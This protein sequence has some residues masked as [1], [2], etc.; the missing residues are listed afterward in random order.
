MEGCGCYVPLSKLAGLW[1]STCNDMPQTKGLSPSS[2]GSSVPDK[3]TEP[4]NHHHV[5]QPI[6]T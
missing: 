3:M 4:M 1:E 5:T 2:K 6:S